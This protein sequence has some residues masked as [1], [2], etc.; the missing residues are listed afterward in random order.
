MIKR[1]DKILIS[2]MELLEEKGVNGVTIKN[3][4]ES[5]KVTEPA[6]YRQYKGKQEL[7]NKMIDEYAIYDEKIEKTILQS[8]LVGKEAVLFYVTR[9]SELYQNYA[10]LTTIM[11]SLDLYFYQE[12]T[13][14][15]MK[16]LMHTRIEFIE[17]L[18]NKDVNQFKLTEELSSFELASI[19]NGMIFS[20]VYEWRMCNKSYELG[21]RLVTL[22]NKI[23]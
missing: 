18:I 4:A 23:L 8:Q 20:Q 10:E 12:D 16:E 21:A 22:V 17:E 5:Q 6:L 13:K 14:K 2:A 3:L 19:I 15:F 11:F 7:V 1:K 9:Y